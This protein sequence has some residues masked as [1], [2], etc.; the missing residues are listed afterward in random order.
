MSKWAMQANFNIYIP[1]AFQ[2][3]KECHKSLSFDP[4]NRSLKFRESSETPSP[5]VGVALGVWGFTPSYSLTLFHTPGSM[6]CDSRAFSCF[7]LLLSLHPCD[8]FALIPR[9]P[10][11]LTL[12]LPL[13]PQPCNPFAL[14]AS[15]K[16]GLRQLK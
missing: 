1:R 8:L 13:G 4:W 14:V 11:A 10:L 16:L 5:K 3:Y 9:L 15:P 12:G 2:W 6:W 7:G